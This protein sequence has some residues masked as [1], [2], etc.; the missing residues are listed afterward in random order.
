MKNNQ[1]VH[2]NH[3]DSGIREELII[4]RRRRRGGELSSH[5]SETVVPQKLIFRLVF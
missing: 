2:L 4:A 5:L 1:N 3:G